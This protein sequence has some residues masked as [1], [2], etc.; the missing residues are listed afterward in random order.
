M[1]AEGMIASARAG[2]TEVDIEPITD[3]DIAVC[4][5]I[6]DTSFGDL[7]RRYGLEDDEYPDSDWLRPI[8]THFLS[9]D[10]S[11]TV[12]AKEGGEPIAFASTFRRDDYWF[13]SFLFVLPSAQGR[14]IGRQLL[15][16]LTPEGRDVVRATVVESFQPASTGLYASMGMAPR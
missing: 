8:L 16:E 11:G 13:L 9:T 15:R 3:A 4:Q 7:H 12:L 14:G 5:A 10:A 2:G 6:F 1:M